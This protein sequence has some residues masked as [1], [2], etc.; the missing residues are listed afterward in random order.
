MVRT[1]EILDLLWEQ[2]FRCALTGRKL[3]PETAVL[4]HKVSRSQGGID[5]KENLQVIDAVVNRMK[6]T[7]STD[8]FLE[9]CREVVGHHDAAALCR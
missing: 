9:L 7:L 1:R 3:T 4:D 6:H 8:E 2:S 5:E